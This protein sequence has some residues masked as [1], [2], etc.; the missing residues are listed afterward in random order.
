M[1]SKST[2]YRIQNT[3]PQTNSDSGKTTHKPRAKLCRA[4]DN[5]EQ[6][7]VSLCISAMAN[8]LSILGSCLT[9][10]DRSRY[11]KL[12]RPSEG[13][14]ARAGLQPE[15]GAIVREFSDLIVIVRHAMT[16]ELQTSHAHGKVIYLGLRQRKPPRLKNLER[17]AI[18]LVFLAPARP[19]LAQADDAIK[20]IEMA[21]T[22]DS[23]GMRLG[24]LFVLHP[25]AD[26]DLT[27]D[28]NV[29]NTDQVRVDDGIAS[30]RPALIVR[31]DF[32]RHKAELDVGA[33]LRRYFD[34]KSENSE[35][36]HLAGRA[37]FDLGN[38]ID[39]LTEAGAA[40][41]IDRRGTAGDQFLSDNPIVYYEKF[42]GLALSRTG[43]TIE[44]IGDAKITK[45][46]YH[47]AQQNNQPID[48]SGR[49]AAVSRAR[50]RANYGLSD[51]TGLFA[52]IAGN[53]VRYDANTA[54]SRDSSGYAVLVGGRLQIT[55]LIDAEAAAGYIRQSFDDPST[56]SVNGVNYRLR[57]NW[58]PTP[59]W[60]IS[61]NGQRTVDPSP[62]GDAPAIITSV[63]QLEASHALNSRLVLTADAGFAKED[64]WT[65]DRTDDRYYANAGAR[66]RLANSV[67]LVAKAGYRK[68]NG[69]A[70]G[71]DYDG[72]RFTIGVRAV[73]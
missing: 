57:V 50:L 51:R 17:L 47:D 68:Q 23:S 18:F 6:S 73:W 27:Y 37:N 20:S 31:S 42:A 67:Q 65:I 11:N 21:Q 35:Q 54:V 16:A 56:K 61:A 3:S 13:E 19:A 64:Y 5:A 2:G 60:K 59:R 1:P 33:E 66:Y 12:S 49:D 38:R 48:L 71:R 36:F 29:Y 25:S 72:A 55:S 8:T 63:F 70:G 7:S 53:Q 28:T 52:E 4:F 9:L 30:F 32:V 45:R 62:R 14:S 58:S 40:R 26:L 15:L 22:D 34:T 43:G 24:P 44:L 10:L 46:D 41:R 39:L 69:G